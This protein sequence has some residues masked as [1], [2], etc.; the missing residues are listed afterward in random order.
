MSYYL[1]KGLAVFRGE[2]NALYPKRDQSSDGWVGDTS[3]SA[4]KSDHNPDYARGGVVRALDIDKDGI[5]ING[6]VE[7]LV[8]KIKAGHAR[9]DGGCYVIF[10]GVIW[11]ATNKGRAST[12]TGQNKHLGHVHFSICQHTGHYDS[13]AAWNLA[14]ALKPKPA[15]KPPFSPIPA[16]DDDMFIIECSNAT[17]VPRL[18]EAGKP[19]RSLNTN[20]P[21]SHAYRAAGV[22]VVRLLAVDFDALVADRA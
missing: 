7:F 3:H 12:Y 1:A 6:L 15:T 4:R 11:T 8:A 9:C 10:N 20:Q 13:H 5:N 16:K 2:I 18:I 22:R 14:A 21:A 19:A 17:R